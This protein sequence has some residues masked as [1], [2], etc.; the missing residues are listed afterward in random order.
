MLKNDNVTLHVNF[1]N[2]SLITFT[3]TQAD[4]QCGHNKCAKFEECQIR[5]M[6]G[7]DYTK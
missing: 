3:E 7:V 6:K 2:K 5:A 4:F 1:S